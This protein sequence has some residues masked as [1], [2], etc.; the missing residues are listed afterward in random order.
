MADRNPIYGLMSTQ[1]SLLDLHH[2]PDAEYSDLP[3]EAHDTFLAAYLDL[4]EALHLAIP[5]KPPQEELASVK[6]ILVALHDFERV[7][8]DIGKPRPKVLEEI[9]RQ[10][11]KRRNELDPDASQNLPPL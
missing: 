10:L 2:Y 8:Q 5:R 6:N 7:L 1:V 4:Q 3:D 9:R 11:E